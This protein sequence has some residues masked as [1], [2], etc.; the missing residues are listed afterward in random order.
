MTTAPQNL[1]LASSEKLTD[2]TAV[3]KLAPRVGGSLG[4]AEGHQQ[5]QR[6]AK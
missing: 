4:N 5:T 2:V 3:R 1:L 6:S